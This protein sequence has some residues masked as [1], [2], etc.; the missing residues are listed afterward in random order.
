[1]IDTNSLVKY[2]FQLH[3]SKCYINY[4]LKEINHFINAL[5]CKYT[6]E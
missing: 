3:I 5:Q 4:P 2:P 6:N 1:M